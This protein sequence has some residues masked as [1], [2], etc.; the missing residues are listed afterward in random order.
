MTLLEM[1]LVIN[2]SITEKNAFLLIICL[3]MEMGVTN[4][5]RKFLHLCISGVNKYNMNENKICNQ[6]QALTLKFYCPSF[7]EG[8][9]TAEAPYEE[10]KK[11]SKTFRQYLPSCHRTYSC[12]H[13]RAHLANHD[14]LISKSFQVFVKLQLHCT[15]AY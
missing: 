1:I 6:L 12:V 7:S 10:H 15:H 13:C 9:N 11:V 2:Y 3:F 5:T 4:V 8:Q 14:E